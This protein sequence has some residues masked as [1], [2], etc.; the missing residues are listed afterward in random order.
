MGRFRFPGD[1][2]EWQEMSGSRNKL[3]R[4]QEAAILA[5]LTS[6]T[7]EDAAGAVGISA[8]T[9]YRWL[10]EPAFDAAYR[11]AKR[12]EFSQAIA[13]LHQMCGPAATT[14]G[15]VMVGH[16]PRPR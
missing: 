9:M 2:R 8:R 4:K 14:P 5:L 6:R 1:G 11:K 7:V 12:T 3:G 15:K 13:R 16:H 10:K